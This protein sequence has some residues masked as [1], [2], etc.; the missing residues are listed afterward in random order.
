MGYFFSVKELF[1]ADMLLIDHHIASCSW[2]LTAENDF[3]KYSGDFS[4]KKIYFRAL[5]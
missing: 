2:F 5:D 3:E 1:V 4:P